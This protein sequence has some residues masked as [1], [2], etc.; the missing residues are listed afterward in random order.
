LARNAKDFHYK[1]AL[2]EIEKLEMPMELRNR[3]KAIK[4]NYQIP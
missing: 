2:D 3:I 4:S 1:E